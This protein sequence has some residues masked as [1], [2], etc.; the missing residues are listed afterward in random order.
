MYHQLR[1]ALGFLELGDP[2]AAWEE[3]ESIPAEE[4]A[5]PV[6]L[7]MRV[8]VYRAK[9]R[10]ME[11]AEVARH[12]T[13]IEPDQPAHWIDR[14]WAERRHLGIPTAQETLLI[15]RD[16]FPQEGIIH[17]NLACYEAVQGKRDEAK[18]SLAR[19]VELE[20]SFKGIALEDEDL[21]GIWE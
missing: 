14:A 7:R 10:W 11:M 5:H 18:V 4:R 1:A 21:K 9:E 6:V 19:A 3:L 13:E 2:D 12:L 8:Q 20:A 16:R 15:A 17:Y